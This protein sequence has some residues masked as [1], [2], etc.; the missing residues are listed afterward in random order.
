MGGGAV[1]DQ[2]NQR[3]GRSLILRL[4]LTLDI[5]AVGGFI[6]LLLVNQLLS[7]RLAMYGGQN[8]AAASVILD[9][10]D[11]LVPYYVAYGASMLLFAL[12]TVGS[13]AWLASESRWV[14]YPVVVVSVA[15]VVFLAVVWFTKGTVLVLILAWF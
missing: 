2:D 13:W 5:L 3:Q 7:G 11:A 1:P 6:V 8:V 15:I 10:M 4:L 12:L 9:L 14:R